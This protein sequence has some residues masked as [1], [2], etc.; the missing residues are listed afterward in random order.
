MTDRLNVTANFSANTG[1]FSQDVG[2]A[3][4]SIVDF[5]NST[6]SLADS[7]FT[8]DNVLSATVVAT[9]NL[10]QKGLAGLGL[11]S[12][13]TADTLIS[14]TGTIV[15]L[16][17]GLV[18]ITDELFNF[19]AALD[20]IQRVGANTSGLE[21][22]TKLAS[23]FALNGQAA[24]DFAQDAAAAFAVVEDKGAF[25]GTLFAGVPDAA[26]RVAFLTDRVRELVDGPLQNLVATSDGLDATYTVL[27]AF[28]ELAKDFE[29]LGKSLEITE[30]G[31]KLS[32]ATGADAATTLTALAQVLITYGDQVD[33]AASAAAKLNGIVQQ[34]V[35]TFPEFADRVGR[36]TGSARQLNLSL[37]ETFG[38]V[39]ALTA[40]LGTDT[41]FTGLESLFNSIIGIGPQARQQ[42]NELGIQFDVTTIQS[43]GLVESLSELFTAADGNLEVLKRIIPDSLGFKTALELVTNSSDKARASIQAISEVGSQGLDDLFGQRTQS[44]IQRVTSLTNGFSSEVEKLGQNVLPA[45]SPAIGVL[46]ALLESFRA[47]PGP[48]KDLIGLTVVVG[49]GFTNLAG[50]GLALGSTLAQLAAL[51]ITARTISLL[52]SG[53]LGEEIEITRTLISTKADLRTIIAQIL[54]FRGQETVAAK[55]ATAAEIANAAAIKAS[56]TVKRTQAALDAVNAEAT[57]LRSQAL[58]EATAAAALEATQGEVSVAAIKARTNAVLLETQADAAQFKVVVLQNQLREQQVAATAAQAAAQQAET[59]ATTQNT[60]ATSANATQKG[61]LGAINKVLF[62]DVGKLTAVL[63]GNTQA[64][65]ANA[66]ASGKLSVANGILGKSV[67]FLANIFNVTKAAV[68]GLV[69]SIGPLAVA[70][71]SVVAAFNLFRVALSGFEDG[72]K[73]TRQSIKDLESALREYEVAARQAGEATAAL[74]E[75]TQK[76]IRANFVDDA[77]NGLKFLDQKVDETLGRFRD[78]ADF[79]PILG[80]GFLRGADALS[81][82]ADKF[83]NEL[84]VAND[85]YILQVE[86]LLLGTVKLANQIREGSSSFE[87]AAERVK[88]LDK[89]AEETAARINE[90]REKFNAGQIDAATFD[91]GVAAFQRIE[92]SIEQTRD[93]LS[94]AQGQVQQTAAEI[95]GAATPLEAFQARLQQAAEAFDQASTVETADQYFKVIQQGFQLGVVGVDEYAQALQRLQAARALDADEEGKGVQVRLQ[96]LQEFNKLRVEAAEKSAD[97]EKQIRDRNVQESINAEKAKQFAGIQTAQETAE[98]IAAIQENALRDEIGALEERNRRLEELQSRGRITEDVATT[99][100]LQNLQRLSQIE[101]QLLDE[102]IKRR[103]QA[104]KTELEGTQAA[105]QARSTAIDQQIQAEEKLIGATE[106]R[107]NALRQEAELA[108]TTADLRNTEIGQAQQLLD[109]EIQSLQRRIEAN[110]KLQE[111]AVAES[112]RARIGQEILSLER[113]QL[114]LVQDRQAKEREALATQQATTTAQLES[115]RQLSAVSLERAEIENRIAVLKAEQ[116]KLSLQ[117]AVDELQTQGELTSLQEA[118]L[119]NLQRQLSGQ[120]Q[121]IDALRQQGESFGLQRELLD[122]VFATRQR[123]L[124]IE[125]AIAKTSLEDQQQRQI[126][127]ELMGAINAEGLT[128]AQIADLIQQQFSEIVG[129]ASLTRQEAEAL[130][131]SL[132]KSSESATTLEASVSTLSSEIRQASSASQTLSSGISNAASESERLS[133]SIINA[134]QSTQFFS[135]QVQGSLGGIQQIIDKIISL[136]GT[137]DSTILDSLRRSGELIGNQNNLWTR[138]AE[139]INQLG[140]SQSSSTIELAKQVDLA[141][142]QALAYSETLDTTEQLRDYIVGLGLTGEA[143]NAQITQTKTLIELSQNLAIEAERRLQIERD[144]VIPLQNQVQLA[145][146]KADLQGLQGDLLSAQIQT[147][148]L[149]I[150][151]ARKRG[152]SEAEI[153]ALEERK[154]SLQARQTQLQLRLNEL[155]TEQQI[156]EKEIEL[157]QLKQNNVGQE[158][159]RNLQE[160]INLLKSIK[161]EYAAAQNEARKL[162]NI[163]IPSVRTSGGGGGGEFNFRPELTDIAAPNEFRVPAATEQSFRQFETS[164][165]NGNQRIEKALGTVAEK[166]D[167]PYINNLSI[168]TPDPAGDYPRVLSQ[169]SKIAYGGG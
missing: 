134:S 167:R 100:R 12:L 139:I 101:G 47:L 42:L 37:D 166:L 35:T 71:G 152:A 95:T 85:E 44:F 9:Q 77:I 60:A 54:G 23:V 2:S 10:E 149:Q 120:E 74:A 3:S 55:G 102:Q 36:L 26:E 59:A 1:K 99:Q 5:R 127:A 124:E 49:S 83:Q 90:L 52:F 66:I 117:A 106:T 105:A 163:R 70:V 40:T 32:A 109:L 144:I 143:F 150:Q 164:L 4:Q 73:Q 69:S 45:F 104:V 157:A 154:L 91:E 145:R 161:S 111:A 53:T 147:V 43:K 92:R 64:L 11:Q 123:Q 121:I 61:I 15:I 72:G 65:I 14:L 96:A 33:G 20:L 112:D 162:E 25:L 153:A 30:A 87:L 22:F 119:E 142:Q 68:I 19:G 46:E 108:K 128:Q 18:K 165:S 57:R 63:L 89:A 160:Q 80:T 113:Q 29:G 110:Q 122:Q 136:G 148:D 8:F 86:E 16:G 7:L 84:I 6:N 27:S 78:L 81:T 158:Q 94:R 98:A 13:R 39:A 137:I 138:T 21:S 38:S 82:Y 97:R 79:I 140:D 135:S 132:V 107:Q 51:L 159:I 17:N 169:M 24:S 126:L 88:V 58:R 146:Q 168:Q 156:L 133:D 155:K 28:P 75:E 125:Q 116:Q 31:L 76:P 67:A 103:E 115:E 41:A 34:G 141:Q 118:Q 130:A 129:S 93:V 48:I 56:N 114:V 131:L 62:L 151:Q 50:A